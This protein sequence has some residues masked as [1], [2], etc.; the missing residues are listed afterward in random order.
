MEHVVTPTSNELKCRSPI[1]MDVGSSKTGDF[2]FRHVLREYRSDCAS[3]SCN[4]EG[5]RVF[6]E[7]SDNDESAREP[8]SVSNPSP[9]SKVL[10][11]SN[12]G[13]TPSKPADRD[14]PTARA[15]VTNT[16]LAASCARLRRVGGRTEEDDALSD[17]E[18]SIAQTEALPT[19]KK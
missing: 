3:R 12:E 11:S 15:A 16:E 14:D 10:S 8:L 19:S 4:D 17:A 2:Q 18:C 6:I 1:A 9:E 13:N 5:I 7:S